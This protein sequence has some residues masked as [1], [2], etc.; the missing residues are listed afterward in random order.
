MTSSSPGIFP[1][2]TRIMG[3]KRKK[4]ARYDKIIREEIAKIRGL[5]VQDFGDSTI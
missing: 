2:K 1:R 4:I 5:M 3:H